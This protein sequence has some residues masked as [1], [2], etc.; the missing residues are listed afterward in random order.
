MFV[1]CFS[2][3]VRS[4]ISSPILHRCRCRTFSGSQPARPKWAPRRCPSFGRTAAVWGGKIDL[5]HIAPPSSSFASPISLFSL[6]TFPCRPLSIMVVYPM[7]AS[8]VNH[9]S[10]PSLPFAS[11]PI[12]STLVFALTVPL[13]SSRAYGSKTDR[14]RLQPNNGGEYIC[15]SGAGQLNPLSGEGARFRALSDR[16]QL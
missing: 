6:K 9:F 10:S 8:I 14:G 15:K 3:H 13:L 2:A 5:L 4:T 16:K 1:I 7:S 11:C 12:R